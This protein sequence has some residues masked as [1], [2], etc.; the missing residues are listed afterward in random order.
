MGVRKV[1]EVI[2]DDDT[3]NPHSN[4]FIESALA[5]L[6]VEIWNWKKFDIFIDTIWKVAPRARVINLYST[7]DFTVLRI[8][9]VR[10]A[11]R[12]SPR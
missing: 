5:E 7:A 12:S 9:R 6:E 8:G 11:L 2:V 1:L 10:T 4:F 3:K